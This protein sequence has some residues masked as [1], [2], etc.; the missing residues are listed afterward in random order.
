MLR[1]VMP[2]LALLATL[3][4]VPAHAHF[5]GATKEIG[6]Y[7]VVFQPFPSSPV[8]GTSSTLNF[9]ILQDGANI[10]NVHAAVTVTE[11]SSGRVVF[12]DPYRLYEISDMTVGYTFESAGDY[13]VTL[14]ARI[15]GHE[16]Y[17]REPLT[18]SFDVTAFNP[19]IPLDELM[20][21]YAAPAAAAAAGIA[22]YLQSKR[23]P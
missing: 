15:I 23:R 8:V 21:Y 3:V 5:F 1:D 7:Q 17:D 11:K 6:G 19:G 4:A 20:L 14:Q 12:Q 9:S 16:K 2:A 13:V 10:G 18:A 22:V